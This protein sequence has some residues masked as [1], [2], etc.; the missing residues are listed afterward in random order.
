MRAGHGV[1]ACGAQELEMRGRAIEDVDGAALEHP[2]QRL[3]VAAVLLGDDLQAP[4]AR[5]LDELL[6]GRVE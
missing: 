1:Q 3:T 6:D 5:E 2:E 4:A